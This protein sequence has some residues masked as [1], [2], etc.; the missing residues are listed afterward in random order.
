MVNGGMDYRFYLV[1]SNHSSRTVSQLNGVVSARS[2]RGSDLLIHHP[3]TVPEAL[4]PGATRRVMLEI[5]LAADIAEDAQLR[6]EL[7][8]LMPAE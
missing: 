8:S 2:N 1:L 6:F 4:P 3:F 7:T 5:P